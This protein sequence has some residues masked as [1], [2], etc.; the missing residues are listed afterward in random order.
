MDD[1]INDGKRDFLKSAAVLGVASSLIGAAAAPR[2]AFAQML[3]TGIREDSSLAK[4]RKEGVINVGYAQTGPWF[5]KD[6]KTG[7]LGG[8]YKDAVEMLAKDLQIKVNW[9]EVTFANST[10]ALR[11][12]DYDLFGS[13]LVYLVQRGL[14]ASY[15]GPL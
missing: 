11:K 13:S 15:I 2:E 8:I 5:Y 14:V 4:V 6:A 1:T 3:E 7:E 10:V 9:K 12:G